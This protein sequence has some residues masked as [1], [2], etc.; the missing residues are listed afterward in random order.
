[1]DAGRVLHAE[2]DLL[3]RQLRD[4][5]GKLCGKVDDLELTVPADGEVY[6]TAVMCGPGGTWLPPRPPPARPLVR[7]AAVHSC[8]ARHRRQ[9]RSHPES[10]NR[11]SSSAPVGISLAV[12][13]DELSSSG[14]ERWVRDHIIS[15]IPEARPVRMSDVMG[16]PV[17][18]AAGTGVGQVSDVRLVQD[19]PYIEGFGNALRLDAVVVGRGGVA[20][21]LGYVR[22]GVRGPWPLRVL[23]PPSSAA[24]TSSP[25]PTSTKRTPASQ[26][27]TAAPTSHAWATPT[28]PP[29]HADCQRSG[30]TRG[31][32]RPSPRHA[33]IGAP[34]IPRE[35]P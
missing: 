34:R 25:G 35:Q 6:V 32:S 19:G 31:G 33:A 2:L 24:P 16:R 26:R 14:G 22:G 11:S 28:M 30:T 29:R 10:P 4:R 12:D 9:G 1:M 17:V 15:N 13:A 20:S 21:R 8:P 5:A 18:D 23:P 3:D 7:D 27:I